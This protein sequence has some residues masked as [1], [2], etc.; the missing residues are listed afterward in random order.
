MPLFSPDVCG[1]FVCVFVRARARVCVCVCVRV[2]VC[3]CVRVLK[4]LVNSFIYGGGDGK[5]YQQSSIHCH[6]VPTNRD[7][8]T[9]GV[10]PVGINEWVLWVWVWV[11]WGVCVWV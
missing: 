10:T 11:C 4:G 9:G 7:I 8:I 3:V 1:S 2:R 5:G 6:S